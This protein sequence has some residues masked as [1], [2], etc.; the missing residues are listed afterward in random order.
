MPS[1][2]AG[3]RVVRVARRAIETYFADGC[4][5]HA[6]GIAYRVL[7]SIVPLAIVIV[8]VTGLVVSSEDARAVVVDAIAHALPR[9]VAS[10]RDVAT[11]I[12]ALTPP[13]T[14]VGLLTL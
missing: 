12:S 14:L 5:Q 11:A 7:F 8:A 2:G 9:S 10:R 3:R 1:A 6:A 13:S 4:S